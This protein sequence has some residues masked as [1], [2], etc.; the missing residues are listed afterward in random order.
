MLAIKRIKFRVG[1]VNK[2]MNHKLQYIDFINAFNNWCYDHPLSK[3][4][5]IVFFKILHIMNLNRWEEWVE[6][7]NVR[8]MD[9]S[10]FSSEQTFIRCRDKLIELGFIE[11]QKGKKR[12]PNRYRLVK[13]F[14]IKQ[15]QKYT[16][17]FASQNYSIT[18]SESVSISDS[19][20]D[21]HNKIEEKEKDNIVSTNV[22]T[23]AN[24]KFAHEETNHENALSKQ[25]GISE[26]K[27][28][29]EF[30]QTEK[31]SKSKQSGI[32]EKITLSEFTQKQAT[33][34]QSGISKNKA[35]SEFIHNS[36][37]K[38]WKAY[39]KKRNKK[40]SF[41]KF[42]SIKNLDEKLVE[43]IIN[44][45]ER[46]KKTEM[47]QK[48]NGQFI[49]LASTFLNGERWNDEIEIEIPNKSTYSHGTPSIYGLSPN[50]IEDPSTDPRDWLGDFC[51]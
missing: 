5:Q 32:S 21:R 29:S 6:I 25:S 3:D 51:G 30:T 40:I 2:K 22:L 27:A 36:F 37:E 26:E 47:W 10:D 38:F 19:I 24:S 49:P 46:Y 42:K 31:E 45:V 7:S 18:A 41:L 28:L 23:C 14:F 15:K 13:E 50:D 20:S 4:V 9:F 11:Y 1:Y 33:N 12:Q 34:K 8:L 16:C 44:S 17:K 39:P 35:M 48:D 43:K